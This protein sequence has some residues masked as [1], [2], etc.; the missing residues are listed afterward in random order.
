MIMFLVLS[1]FLVKILF[2]HSQTVRQTEEQTEEQPEDPNEP[3][4]DPEPEPEPT[5]KEEFEVCSLFSFSSL[6]FSDLLFS[7]LSLDGSTFALK[8]NDVC[9]S[10]G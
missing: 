9:Q 6:F 1:L 3:Q 5:H 7:S 8:G 4:E 2:S 10:W